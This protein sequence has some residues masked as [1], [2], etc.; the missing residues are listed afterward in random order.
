MK[1]RVTTLLATTR[2]SP[3]ISVP[4][5]S[6]AKYASQHILTIIMYAFQRCKNK[7]GSFRFFSP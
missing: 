7:K 2:K 6:L 4:S 3:S 1:N 5:F